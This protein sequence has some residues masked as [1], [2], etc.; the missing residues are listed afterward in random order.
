MKLDNFYHLEYSG[1]C[2]H[3]HCQTLNISANMSLKKVKGHWLKH[4]YN[5]ESEDNSL[6]ILI[7][8]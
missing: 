3:L 2:L 1:Y 7:D 6:N 4:E 5:N 8:N